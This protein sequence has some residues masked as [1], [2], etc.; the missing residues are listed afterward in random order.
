MAS[1]DGTSS[2]GGVVPAAGAPPSAR[3]EQVPQSLYDA[4]NDKNFWVARGWRFAF[5]RGWPGT[6]IK[7]N[8]KGYDKAVTEST[9]EQVIDIFQ[10]V[11]ASKLLVAPQAVKHGRDF[12]QL[13]KVKLQ[14]MGGE[15]TDVVVPHLAGVAFMQD[16]IDD[17]LIFLEC[18]RGSRVGLLARNIDVLHSAYSESLAE[19][20]RARF[21]FVENA[22]RLLKKV[23]VYLWL[24]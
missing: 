5:S 6:T 19:A 9:A 7:F 4:T 2:G 23:A 3:S 16:G 1:S 11:L 12:T 17:M 22:G 20:P 21:A 24:I 13:V 15:H 18:V 10:D 14:P 8:D